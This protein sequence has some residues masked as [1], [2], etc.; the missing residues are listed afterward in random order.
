MKEFGRP[1]ARVPD[2]PL[3]SPMIASELKNAQF[4]DGSRLA[5]LG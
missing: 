4:S 1:G 3:D 5:E 2:A